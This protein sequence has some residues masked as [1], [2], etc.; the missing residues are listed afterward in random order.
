MALGNLLLW[1]IKMYFYQLVYKENVT[2]L[3]CGGKSCMANVIRYVMKHN[4]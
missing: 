1:I 3:S 2:S 4:C